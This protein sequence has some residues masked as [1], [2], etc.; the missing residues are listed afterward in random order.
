MREIIIAKKLKVY[1]YQN[2]VTQMELAN[3]LGVTAQAISKWE[4]EE[5]YPDITLLPILA[6]TIGCRVDEFCVS[7]D[8]F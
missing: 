4:N 1:R 6:D 5:C 8:I 3:L 7:N 2:R